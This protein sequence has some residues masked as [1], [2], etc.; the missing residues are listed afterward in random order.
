LFVCRRCST[1]LFQSILLY[2]HLCPVLDIV[3]IVAMMK[4]NSIEKRRRKNLFFWQ[5]PPFSTQKGQT[6]PG[7]A[8]GKLFPGGVAVHA[9]LAVASTVVIGFIVVSRSDFRIVKNYH[10]RIVIRSSHIFCFFNAHQQRLLLL[11]KGDSTG[12]I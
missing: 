6:W 8:T 2:L 11:G 3:V 12:A 10:S 1:W 4:K 5:I 9:G 7:K